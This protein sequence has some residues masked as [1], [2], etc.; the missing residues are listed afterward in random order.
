MCDDEEEDEGDTDED[1]GKSISQTEEEGRFKRIKD[2][3]EE[4]KSKTTGRQK[5][6]HAER[7]KIAKQ[8][9]CHR[10]LS[11]A[12]DLVK[13]AAAGKLTE[14]DDNSRTD[15]ASSGEQDH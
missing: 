14:N 2:G 15:E 5:H 8:R 3:E 12:V 1:D 4:K 10:R 13:E 6:Q 7:G 9:L 11:S